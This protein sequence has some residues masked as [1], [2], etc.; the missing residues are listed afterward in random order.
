[1][2]AVSTDKNKLN[3]SGVLGP[4][5]NGFFAAIMYG[6]LFVPLMLISNKEISTDALAI[7]ALILFLV[8]N[9]IDF[10]STNRKKKAT[11]QWVVVGS[12]I[13]SVGTAVV[14]TIVS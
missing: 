4:L 13:V 9:L 5:S 10:L 12:F 2:S 6:I 3:N 7:P 11:P 8:I 14:M 1:M